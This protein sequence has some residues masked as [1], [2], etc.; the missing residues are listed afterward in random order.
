MLKKKLRTAKSSAYRS[1]IVAAAEGLFAEHGYEGTKIQ[2]I[3][4]QS[5]LSLGT[6]YSVFAGKSDVCE[7]VHNDRL[8]ELFRLTGKTMA[9]EHSAARRLLQGNRV[10]VRWLAEH[11]AFLRI[12]LN[13]STA[14]ASHPREVGANLIDAWHRGIKLIGSVMEEAMREGDVHEGDPLIAARL[15][16]AMQQVFMSAWVEDGMRAEPDELASQVEAQLERALF[17][18]KR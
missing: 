6:L 4:A 12:H 7:A 16:V 1:L 13:G 11:P 9:S 14:W 3:A 18:R 8:G 10:F 17:R 5:G 2:D 15:M